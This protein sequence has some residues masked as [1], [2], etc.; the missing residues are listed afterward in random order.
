MSD[1]KMKNISSDCK[2]VTI[3]TPSFKNIFDDI[4]CRTVE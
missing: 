1:M 3:I 2:S 4:H